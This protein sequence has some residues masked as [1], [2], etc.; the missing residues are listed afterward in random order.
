MTVTDWLVAGAAG[1]ALLISFNAY[2]DGK[3]SADAA[4]K[5]ADA[6]DRS[7]E[8]AEGS[9]VEAVRSAD[10]AEDSADT[11]RRERERA[12]E[13]A[14][15]HFVLD[16]DQRSGVFAFTN[17]GLDSALRVEVVVNLNGDHIRSEHGDIIGGAEFVVDLQ[18]QHD[19]AG[20]EASARMAASRG[21]GI[22]L[23][24]AARFD[25]E[26]RISWLSFHSSPGIQVFTNKDK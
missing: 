12:I 19:E 24:A 4:V 1:L 13:R 9:R 15:V 20:A 23:I 2:Y 22:L 26:I 14:D 3:R 5:S 8:S 10:A 6:S 7:A 16:R 17:A 18:A 25:Y 11:A 21:S